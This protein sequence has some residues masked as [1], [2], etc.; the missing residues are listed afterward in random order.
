MVR[1][2]F[3]PH[4]IKFD[5]FFKNYKEMVGKGYYFQ[6]LP[7][8]RGYGG[9]HFTRQ[10]GGNMGGALKF[11]A[12][13]LLPILKEAGLNVGKEFGKEAL[14]TGTRIL[15]S[16]LTGERAKE[17]FKHEAKEGAERLIT[18]VKR[19]YDS[20]QQRGG[21]LVKKRR[22]QVVQIKNKKANAMFKKLHARKK[23]RNTFGLF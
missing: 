14:S 1:V 4:S 5:E 13:M 21:S 3:D 16:L 10:F 18:R 15:G 11:V 17:A 6:G 12:R 7:Y 20:K 22:K 9:L 23:P 8:Q 2:P 19:K